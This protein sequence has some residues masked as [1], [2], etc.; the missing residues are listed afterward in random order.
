M[1]SLRTRR[2]EDTF[3]REGVSNSP[4]R[5]FT[6]MTKLKKK[7]EEYERLARGEKDPG[8]SALRLIYTSYVYSQFLEGLLRRV[9]DFSC[10]LWLG[11]R[12][13]R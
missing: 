5:E 12:L 4:C 7:A 8:K 10:C 6:Y 1:F 11:C 3:N 2:G 9:K 13:G